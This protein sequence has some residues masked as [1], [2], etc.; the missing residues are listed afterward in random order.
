MNDFKRKELEK[1]LL[2]FK[3]QVRELWAL[4]ANTCT[5]MCDESKDFVLHVEA[6]VDAFSELQ[7]E[8]EVYA[9]MLKAKGV[10]QSGA[11]DQLKQSS[12]YRT[13]VVRTGGKPFHLYPE[14]ENISRMSGVQRFER[15]GTMS[16]RVLGDLDV[17]RTWPESEDTEGRVI[18][19]AFVEVGRYSLEDV[20][21]ILHERDK[22]II[23]TQGERT[24]LRLGPIGPL[25]FSTEL[26]E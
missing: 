23:I 16:G 9:D 2:W 25:A 17:K 13:E 14:K 3:A 19:Y 11:N 8:N 7:Q 4:Q 1:S 26:E 24:Q 5:E 18:E 10:L 20:E 6:L 12:L 21:R 22:E 15:F